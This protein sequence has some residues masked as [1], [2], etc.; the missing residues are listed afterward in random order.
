MK[1]E[2]ARAGNHNG[3][4][5]SQ[6]DICAM[7]ATFGGNVPVT[8]GH[9]LDDTMPAFGWVESLETSEDC[10]ALIGKIQLGAELE[11]AMS[12]GKYKN[13]SIGAGTDEEDRM[14]LHH[15]AFL[16]AVPPMIKNLR[17]IEMGDTSDILTLSIEPG[18]CS[19]LLSDAET[20]EY[21]ALRAEK[22]EKTLKKLSD[23]SAGKLP[24]GKREALMEFA[25]ALYAEKDGGSFVELLSDI[26]SSVKSPVREG[27][28]AMIT[29]KKAADGRNL[30]RKI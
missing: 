3:I 27:L 24:F 18:Q 22:K 17:V 9:E 11:Q 7:A 1:L 2:L 26:F 30:F 12:E 15:V 14:Y 19:V 25:D 5:I 4:S 28:S 13:W 29:S 23:A 8:I 20:A 10:M 16:G 21:A 6:E